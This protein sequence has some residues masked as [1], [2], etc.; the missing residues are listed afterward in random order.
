L[1]ICCE[2]TLDIV[3]V[4]THVGRLATFP[5]LSLCAQQTT[6]TTSDPISDLLDSV[7]VYTD[8][9]PQDHAIEKTIPYIDDTNLREERRRHAI[10][11]QTLWRTR[12]P[13]D[14]AQ[15]LVA[16]THF[17][18]TVYAAGQTLHPQVEQPLFMFQACRYQ[19]NPPTSASNAKTLARPS[20]ALA[21]LGYVFASKLLLGTETACGAWNAVCRGALPPLPVLLFSEK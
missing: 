20:R 10:S 5:Q 11:I 12:R 8:P 2:G 6:K 14:E 15:I 13:A 4:Q 7:R 19:P 21:K 1:A 17:S 18:G 16:T 9:V 3:V